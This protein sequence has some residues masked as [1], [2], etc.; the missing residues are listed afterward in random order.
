[1]RVPPLP[2][3]LP[4]KHRQQLNALLPAGALAVLHANDLLPTNADGTMPFY[5]NS[6]LFYLTNILQEKSILLLFPQAQQP[7]QRE[8]LFL[9]AQNP[10][11]SIWEGDKLSKEAASNLSGIQ[12]ICW[13]EDFEKI[14]AQLMTE[15]TRIYLNTNEHYRAQV[16]VESRDARFIRWCKKR[17]PLH[18]YDRVAP[19]LYTLRGVKD[20]REITCMRRACALTRDGF[21]RVLSFVQD[22]VKE[23]E[24]EAEYLHEFVRRGSRGFAYMPI[25][26]S[27]KNACVL[28]YT[29]NYDTCLAGEVL[30]MD[31]GAEYGNYFAD[32]TRCLP[33]SGRFNSRQR[34]VYDAVLSVQRAVKK[35]LKPG[36][37]LNTLQKEAEGMVEK[38]LCDLGLLSVAA[39][40]AQDPEKPLLRQYFMHGVSH[41]IGLDVHD[42]VPLHRPLVPGMVITVEPGIYLREERLGVRLENMVVITEQGCEDLMEDIPIE[43]EE[44]EDLMNR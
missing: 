2:P 24:V 5:Q 13:L 7:S 16:E 6:D 32:M 12:N 44:I 15:A 29:Q 38:A 26:A 11:L 14:F 18:S 3:S 1:M 8:I 42:V 22:G 19:L 21:N 4:T 27:G 10:L 40:K 41:H 20:T 30:L 25:V 33:V 43:A 9:M 36:K 37:T 23:Y 28:H 17:Y 31:V 35:A 39:I 34:K